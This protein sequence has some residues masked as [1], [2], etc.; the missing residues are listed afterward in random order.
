VLSSGADAVEKEPPE[1]QNLIARLPFV[2]GS[3]KILGAC[4]ISLSF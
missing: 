3:S 2:L 1:G 4:F